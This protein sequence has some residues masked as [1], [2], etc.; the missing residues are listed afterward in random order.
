MEFIKI[1]NFYS[2]SDTVK[3]ENAETNY[4]LGEN[5]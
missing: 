5:I 4:T 3:E 1:K 2:A